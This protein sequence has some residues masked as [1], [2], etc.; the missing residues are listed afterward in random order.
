MGVVARGIIHS[1]REQKWF[2]ASR[3]GDTAT[4]TSGSCGAGIR[5]GVFTAFPK[6]NLSTTLA[7]AWQ[8]TGR[9]RL[10][11]AFFSIQPQDRGTSNKSTRRPPKHHQ[12]TAQRQACTASILCK[13]S[14]GP[15]R[16]PYAVKNKTQGAPFRGA[17]RA[18]T[19]ITSLFI[20]NARITA[21]LPPFVKATPS[22][23]GQYGLY[24][25][26]K[27]HWVPRRCG[28]VAQGLRRTFPPDKA[29][30]L[31]RFRRHVHAAVRISVSVISEMLLQ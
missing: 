26:K 1:T 25:N 4:V 2:I 19:T 14:A 12:E 18:H 10:P 23:H 9:N 30:H 13:H 15:R 11:S 27:T 8:N 28:L 22:S 3:M 16:A 6:F 24:R 7:F 17:P 21:V 29:L 31:N 5:I 20:L